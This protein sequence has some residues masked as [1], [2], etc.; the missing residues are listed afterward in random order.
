M[1]MVCLAGRQIVSTRAGLSGSSFLII[2]IV[3]GF[4]SFLSGF[5]A[6][7]DN[8]VGYTLIIYLIQFACYGLIPFY[9]VCIHYGHKP[10]SL[11]FKFD[12]EKLHLV[13][14][15]GAIWGIY[16]YVLNVLITIFQ[17]LIFPGYEYNLQ[18]IL[19]IIQSAK[20]SWE[21]AAL[22]VCIVI[23]AP[24]SEEIFFR[25]F[26][27]TAIKARFGRRIAIFASAVIFSL[28]HF[29]LWVLLPMFVGGIG[30]AYIYDKYG[31]ILLNIFAHIV[32][33][34]IALSLFFRILRLI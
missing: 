32:W 31:N 15:F 7:A 19:Q 21:I 34:S 12:R 8:L 23:L 9:I 22:V 14:H 13:I 11:G 26:L 25:G 18:S 3:W 28:L 27:F 29:D 5:A 24:I 10:S 2:G 16:L 4:S 30:F 33:N 6:A 17:G 20:N 1:M